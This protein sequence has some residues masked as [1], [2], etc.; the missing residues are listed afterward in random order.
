MI[1]IFG[2]AVVVGGSTGI[3]VPLDLQRLVGFVGKVTL[4]EYWSCLWVLGPCLVQ[5]GFKRV[6]IVKKEVQAETV[7]NFEIKW[8][9]GQLMRSSVPRRS[10]VGA[11]AAI[12]NV[13]VSVLGLLMVYWHS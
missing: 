12:T 1:A 4:V 2:R 5:P 10:W 9:V 6:Q 3:V 8:R 7:L 13:V 11:I